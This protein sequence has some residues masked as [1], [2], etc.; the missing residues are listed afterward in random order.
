[1]VKTP[2][3]RHSKSHRE[4][5]TIELEP[6]S[7]SRVTDTDAPAHE[8]T[9]EQAE[10]PAS[11]Y[12][13]EDMEAAAASSAD[14]PQA[15]GQTARAPS[16]YDFS[17][18][19][20]SSSANTTYESTPARPETRQ[21]SLG[22]VAAG[23]VGGIIT[24]AGAGALQFA[25]NL[26][27]ANRGGN[28]VPEAVQAEIAQMKQAIAGLENGGG[29]TDPEIN[30]RVDALAQAIDQLKADTSGLQQAVS[31][32]GTGD[33]SGPQALETRLTDA[34]ASIAALRQQG[35][36]QPAESD[37]AALGEKLAGLETLARSAD[38]A[39]K[40]TDGRLNTLEQTIG[41]L[42]DKVEAQ[43]AQPKVALSIAASALKSAIDRG[44]PFE[45]ELETFAAI[46]P[47]T[48]EIQS[49]RAHAGQ[50][51]P[52]R[53]E[54]L[55]ESDAA[56]KAMIAAAKPVAENAGFFDRLL[57]S[58]ESLV[59]VRPI[60][61]VEGAGVPETAARMEFALKSGNL[62]QAL[63]EY[64][65]LPEPA[66]AAGS[67]FAE[68]IRARAEAERLVDQLVAGAMKA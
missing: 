38:E 56:V 62:E 30:S 66:K 23:I 60:G 11:S 34:E 43:A 29:S 33:N 64:A 19:K 24:L 26:P 14:Q 10:S 9:V 45:A 8:E 40:T 55:R 5:V 61:A 63:A 37:V 42:S 17:S 67:A 21:G 58:A 20:G 16:D 12:V 22:L 47:P 46:A 49:L 15:E 50:G 39:A 18:A 3:T 6:E 35:S 52:S 4:P 41:T 7:V 36:E 57:N 28:Q 44:A 51:V 25:G 32:A 1:M 54:L 68:K 27:A 31:A 65:S 2:K 13:V 48:A 59:S 53:D